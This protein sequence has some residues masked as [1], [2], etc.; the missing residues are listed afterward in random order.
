VTTDTPHNATRERSRVAL[1]TC[2][3]LPELDPDDRL[4]VAALAAR[5]VATEPAVW[6][7]PAVDW[8]RYDL[9]VLRSSW[10]YPARRDAFVSWAHRV[11]RLANPADVVAWSTDKRY[12]AELAGAGLPVVPTTWLAPGHRWPAPARG[13]Y[14]IKP[15]VSVGSKHAGR[16]DLADP[17]HRHLALE[18][19][20]ALRSAGQL[21]MI[22]PY[23]S[24]V[25][26]VGE[27][28]LVY[29]GGR[30]SHAVRKDAML[31]GPHAGV[32]GLYKPEKI[33]PRTATATQRR[34][35]DAVLARVP[36]GSDRLL[37]ARVDL[38]PGPGGEPLL[39]ELELAEPS[40]FL[41][42][43]EGAADRFAAAV[44]AR[45]A[46]RSS[47]PVRAGHLDRRTPGSR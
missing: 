20:T 6:D 10:D 36:G 13:E 16:Y 5:G 32:N 31:T 33:T 38:I 7:D 25:D 14:V 23:L 35:A 1:I 21:V 24:A 47:R 11:P 17:R 28:A 4:A 37:Y 39:V 34:V 40:L 19:V 8:D 27:T 30:Y 46:D 2:A 42:Y 45:V 18:L 44:H 41:G 3:A 43:A 15:A 9:A 12:L 22:Q 29:F 26:S